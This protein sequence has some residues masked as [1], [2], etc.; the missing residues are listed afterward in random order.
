MS[1]CIG[2]DLGTTNSV[3]GVWEN[4]RVE[5][6]TNDM[7]YRTTP[8]CVAFTKDERLVGNSAKNNL[9]IDPTNT[10]YDIKRIIGRKFIDPTVKSDSKY[11]PFKVFNKGGVPNVRATYLGKNTLFTPEEIS[12]MILEKLKTIAEE[13]IGEP[14]VDAVITVPAYFNDSQRQA[15]KDAGT[16]A[17][18]NVV[19]IIN[20]PTAAAIAY[21]MDK[22][23]DN[24][25]C[26]LIFDFGG[27]TLDISLLTL[28][29]GVFEVIAT[30]GNTHLGGSDIDNILVEYFSE[31]FEREHGISLNDNPR[32]LRRLRTECERVKI[33]LSAKTNVQLVIEALHNGI[34]FK[35]SLS[36]AKFESII[37][38]I[39]EECFLPLKKVLEDAHID[40]TSIDEIILV[41]GSTRIPK[42]QQM[43]R[44]YFGGK[45]LNKSINPDEAVA[46]G[47]AVYA[48]VLGEE[49]DKPDNVVL[50]DVTPLSLGVEAT[51][52]IMSI[53]IP[54]NTTIPFCAS[55]TFTTRVDNQPGVTIQVFE[56]ER[57]QTRHNNELGRFDLVDLPKRPRGEVKIQVTFDIDAD[58]ILSVSAIEDCT[59]KTN[60]ITI[61]NEKMRLTT[62]EVND[63]VQKAEE[64][65]QQ[66]DDTRDRIYARNN[67]EAFI[68]RTRNT[69]SNFEGIQDRDLG[70]IQKVVT[71]TVEWVDTHTEEPKEVYEQKLRDLEEYV[72]PIMQTSFTNS[73][74][75]MMGEFDI[76][77]EE[78]TDDEVYC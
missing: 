60:E 47:A 38:H 12:S 45:P 54:R 5:I 51:G 43:I 44:A 75:A 52:G 20:E 32:A 41:G 18:L 26:I 14:L 50:L 58:G 74:R 63:L 48:S 21:G 64:Y 42:I 17:G 68:F 1:K 56:G 71:D 10:I 22:R 25:L 30:S 15:T 39:F 57:T 27:G 3:V 78:E 24:E 40:K 61:C 34:D 31:E 11:W 33:E 53:I 4:G 7:G 35:C 9:I 59:G 77:S 72:Q 69:I 76:D 49:S 70:I 37:S 6:I 62:D 66:D 65:R 16:I 29:D 55:Q 28:V 46:Y 19:R 13:Y 2:I 8:S 67:L 36:R 23:T 73:Q